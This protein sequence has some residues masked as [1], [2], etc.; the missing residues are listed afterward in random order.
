[1]PVTTD[2]VPAIAGAFPGRRSFLK[3]GVAA[4]AGG[5]ALLTPL[6]A[7]VVAFVSPLWRR[8]GGTVEFRRVTALAAL[9][10]DGIPRRFPV[11]AE[12]INAWN[13]SPKV[14]VGAVYLV[15]TSETEV[16]AFNVVCPHAGC[17]VEYAPAWR[18]FLCPCH[19]STFATDGRINETSSPSPRGLDE[20]PVVLRPDGGVWVR[21][22]NF[23][24]GTREKHPA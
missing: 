13:R 20:L 10:A 23:R 7:G 2:R 4:V 5:V 12:R 3:A 22:Q 17:V 24:T 1:M 14:A 16:R 15:R 8:A 19:N 21:F 11:R 6:A 18:G 9:A